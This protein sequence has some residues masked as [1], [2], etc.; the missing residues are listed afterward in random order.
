MDIVATAAQN[1]ED[2]IAAQP[3]EGTSCQAT[4]ALHVTYLWIYGASPSE[5]FLELGRQAASGARDQSLALFHT[6]ATIAA[7][8]HCECRALVRQDFDLLQGLCQ[9]VPIIGGSWA[10]RGCRWQSFRQWLW[11]R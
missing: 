9:G 5:Q 8:D 2:G 11:R 1:G 4:V 3:L 10:W 7:I 6:K